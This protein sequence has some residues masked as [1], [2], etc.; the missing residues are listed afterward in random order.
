MS[1]S[2]QTYQLHAYLDGELS[3]DECLEIEKALDSDPELREQL[4]QLNS[5]KR[6]VKDSLS[7]VPVPPKNRKS[8][9]RHS[10]F[11]NLPRTAAASLFLGLVLGAGLFKAFVYQIDSFG[12][13]EQAVS[14]NYLVH[15][16]SDSPKKQQKAI[17]KIEE[18]LTS[19]SSE[20]QVELISNHKGVALFDVRNPNNKDLTR[21]LKEYDN[22]TLSACQ[23]ALERAKQRGQEINVMSRVR[24]DKPAIDAVIERLHSR[25][26]YTK[27]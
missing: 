20:S 5:L 6:V 9:N 15:L 18:L 22:L 26:N 27:I 14:D 19:V 2:I 17:Q 21:L 4:A 10:A 3:E 13:V 7:S 8:D 11:W 16:D 23:R 25:W 1:H 12:V 24:Q